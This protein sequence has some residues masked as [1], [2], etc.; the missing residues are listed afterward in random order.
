VLNGKAT[1]LKKLPIDVTL[2]FVHEL[3]VHQIELEMQNEDLR[4]V[5]NELEKARN[6]FSDLYDFAPIGYF[7]FDKKGLILQVNLT[8]SSPAK[9]SP[10]SPV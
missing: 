4:R 1:D 10:L 2:S 8:V 5:Q 7:T 3:Q 6:S 9:K